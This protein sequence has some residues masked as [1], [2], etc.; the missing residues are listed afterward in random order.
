MRQVERGTSTKYVPVVVSDW[1]KL[2]AEIDA[3]IEQGALAV[4]TVD[5]YTR[6]W[7]FWVRHCDGLGV[8]PLRAP[9]DAFTAFLALRKADGSP[10][11]AAT[12]DTRISAIA[13][14]YDKHWLVPAYEKPDAY[15]DWRDLRRGLKRTDQAHR[16]ANGMPASGDEKVAPLMRAELLALLAAEPVPS[17]A[18]NA[19]LAAVLLSFDHDIPG[20]Q[21]AALQPEAVEINGE[22]VSVGPLEIRC[23]HTARVRGVPWDC[24]ACAVQKVVDEH[25]GGGL[26]LLHRVVGQGK[27]ALLKERISARLN[28]LR[29]SGWRGAAFLTTDDSFPGPVLT[30][31]AELSEWQLA[32]LRR[33]LALRV[34]PHRRG[35]YLRARAWV[36]LSWSG[37]FRMCGDLVRLDRGRVRRE[38]LGAGWTLDLS[39]TKDDPFGRKAVTR[40]FGWATDRVVEG[41]DLSAA[42]FLSEYLCVRDAVQGEDGMLFRTRVLTPSES[43]MPITNPPKIAAIALSRLCEL[44]GLADRHYTAKSCRKGFADQALEDGWSAEDVS[45]ALRHTRMGTTLGH[46]VA[47]ASSARTA[48]RLHDMVRNDE[49]ES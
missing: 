37:G 38:V 7:S 20:G 24:T 11:A 27:P 26:P 16:R 36:S 17:A 2:N 44:A 47:K 35:D 43:D 15:A 49:V 4:S 25:Q 8:D 32:G 1:E 19:W 48:A 42:R 41:P 14:Y 5:N 6:A 23:D 30:P 9:Y 46:Y 18:Q 39:A 34:G 31:A 10:Y 22:R 40:S 33:A 3:F 45:E 28:E 13:H 21:L 29:N 12:V